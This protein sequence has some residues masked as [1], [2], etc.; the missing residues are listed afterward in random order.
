MT[1]NRPLLYHETQSEA[2]CAVHCLNAVVQAPMFTEV[3][4][5]NAAQALEAQERELRAAAGL[6]SKEFLEYVASGESAY[7]ADDGNFSIVVMNRA[8]EA[9]GLEAVAVEHPSMVAS[10]AADPSAFDAYILNSGAHWIALRKLYG[11]WYNLD[12]LE[13]LPTVVTDFY[14]AAFLSSMRGA[15]YTAFVVQG[16]FMTPRQFQPDFDLEGADA[17]PHYK[18]PRAAGRP[19][20]RRTGRRGDGG[21]GDGGG[22]DDEESYQLA[23]ALAMSMQ[24][25]SD[26]VQGAGGAGTG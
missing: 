18:F 6:D 11:T 15:G 25:A 4:L 13:D 23:L 2:L 7:V 8:L 17:S 5:A 9:V 3:D 1:D 16:T 21:G 22:G 10:V 20:R 24:A 12:S 14:L 26:A 19:P